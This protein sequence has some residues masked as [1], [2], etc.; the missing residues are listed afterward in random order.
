[1]VQADDRTGEEP[2]AVARY[3]ATL[4]RDRSKWPSPYKYLL[5]QDY[6]EISQ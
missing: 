1:M 4:D 2:V 6:I 3:W 5:Q